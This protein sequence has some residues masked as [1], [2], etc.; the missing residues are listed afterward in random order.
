ESNGGSRLDAA[1]VAV[2]DLETELRDANAKRDALQQQERITPPVLNEPAGG[3]AGINQIA[4]AEEKLAELRA[5]FT[6][7]HPD[8]IMAQQVLA[9]LKTAP[10]RAEPP[11]TSGSSHS[12]AF[13]NPV[14]EQVKLR[15]IE[16]D[17][18]IVSLQGGF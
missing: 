17:W 1:R 7:Q 8:V 2:R 4:A 5:R 13:A 12:R 11:V 9:A 16:A 10:K 3:Q 18:T 14:Y 6:A 15:L